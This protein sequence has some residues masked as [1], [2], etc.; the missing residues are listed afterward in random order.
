LFDPLLLRLSGQL[1]I[2]FDQ[3]SH[4][5]HQFDHREFLAFNDVALLLAKKIYSTICRQKAIQRDD[6]TYHF[7]D[8]DIFNNNTHISFADAL[9]SIPFSTAVDISD[10]LWKK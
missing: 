5:Q 3:R 7:P 8:H 10:L 1:F 9:G 6:P 2:Q 4:L